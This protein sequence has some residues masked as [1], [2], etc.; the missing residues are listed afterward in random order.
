[1]FADFPNARV[2]DAYMLLIK[3]TGNNTITI[4]AGAGVTLTGTA[5]IATNVTRL[6]SVTFTSATALV[7]Q[8]VLSGTV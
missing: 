2:G 4:T 8:N 5:T 7:M 3:N 1:M 6:Y